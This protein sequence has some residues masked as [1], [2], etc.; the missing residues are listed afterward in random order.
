MEGSKL[1][2]DLGRNISVA[3]GGPALAC[4][5]KTPWIDHTG[6]EIEKFQDH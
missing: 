3:F 1:D 6:M 4:L 2:I 5:T